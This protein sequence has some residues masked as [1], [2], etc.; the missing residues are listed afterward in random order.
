MKEDGCKTA[1]LWNDKSTYGAGLARNIKQSAQST[2]VKIENE[3]GTDKNAPNYRSIASKI[4]SDCFVFAGVTGENGVQIYKD[5]AA[6]APNAKLYGPDGVAESGFFDPKDGG[7][8]AKVADKVKLT[9]ATLSPKSYGEVGKK[10]FSD[11]AKEY[12]DKNPNPYSIYGYE[13]MSLALDAIK[14]SGTGK[15]EDIVKALFATKNRDSPLGTYSIDPNGD[16]TLT[17][18]GVYKIKNGQQVF[19]ETVKAQT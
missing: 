5:V 19:L 4:K 18:Y 2:G 9:V 14:R 13:A 12:G 16:T 11:F 6:A 3:Q 15:R 1:T 10:F 17:D 8:P 7:I